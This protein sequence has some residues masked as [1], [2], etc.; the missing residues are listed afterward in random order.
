MCEMARVQGLWLQSCVARLRRFFASRPS[1]PSP[2][3]KLKFL[4]KNGLGHDLVGGRMAA[5]RGTL[6]FQ[7]KSE[8]GTWVPRPEGLAPGRTTASELLLQYAG[9]VR[10]GSVI[11][12]TREE[13]VLPLTGAGKLQS[14]SATR[15]HTNFAS[16]L[17]AKFIVSQN[18]RFKE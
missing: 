7:D 4:R 3:S 14:C 2:R 10:A 5:I 16:H 11:A 9:V 13:G 15:F 1:T 6:G 17:R 18:A 12:D 8:C